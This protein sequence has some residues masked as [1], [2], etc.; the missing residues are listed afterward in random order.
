MK[1]FN[2]ATLAFH[3]EADNEVYVPILELTS[4]L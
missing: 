4:L 1:N 3:E 2:T